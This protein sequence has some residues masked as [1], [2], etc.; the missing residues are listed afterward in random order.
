MKEVKT[1]WF[2]VMIVLLTNSI[3]TFAQK[4]NLPE[5][6]PLI[7]EIGYAAKVNDIPAKWYP[8]IVP[9]AVQLDLAKALKYGTYY[10]AE[11][12]KDYLWMED[13]YF[14]YR[15][16]FTKP[17]V[18]EN[19][20]CFFFSKGID[21]EFE[22]WLNGEKLFHQEGMFKPVKL[23]LSSGLKDKNDLLVKIY[24]IPKL[25]K[26]PND[27][28]QAAQSVKPA[29]SYGWDWHPRLVPIGIWD[30]TGLVVQNQSGITDLDMNYSLDKD[31]KTAAISNQIKGVN[32]KNCRYVWKI[33]DALGNGVLK[34]EGLFNSEEIVLEAEID[35]IQLWW[36][37]DQGQPFLYD[38]VFQ[39][40]DVN[41]RLIDQRT[42]KIGFRK[43]QL[44]MNEGAWN[45]PQGFPKSQSI[46]PVQLE[47]NGR[48]IFCKGT[49]WV[50]PEIFPGIITTARYNE[51]LDRAKEAN[52][53][54]LRVWGGGIINKNSFYDLCDEK[55]ILVWQEFPLACNNYEGTQHYLK[56][57][58]QESE[59]IIKRLKPHPSLAI[60]CGGNELYNS[61]SKMT[62]QSLAIRLLNSQCF[63]LDPATP[64]LPTSPVMGMGHGHYV[65]RDPDTNE[66]VFQVMSRANNTAY[67]EFGMPA[68][69][70]LEVLK[71]IIPENELWPPKPGTSW[72]SHH[73]FKAW[74]GNTWLMPDMLSDYFGEAKNLEELIAN[75][76]LVQCEGYKCIYEEAR[77]QKPYCSMA[78]NWCFN[79]PW[80]TAANNSLVNWPN[81]PKPGFYAVKNACRPFMASA[82]IKKFK[83]VEGEEFA[84]DIWI[85]NDLPQQAAGGK[86]S[87]K[88]V[89]DSAEIKLLDWEFGIP[90][91]NTNLSGPSVRC[92]LPAWETDCF[93][94]ILEV[95]GHSEYNSEYTFLYSPTTV[96]KKKSNLTNY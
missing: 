78:L 27:R 66:E 28:T 20:K 92:H 87:V 73:A 55:G 43:V 81:K 45:E 42:S 46:P 8:A 2:L 19:Q 5:I 47:I 23:D 3:F 41:G 7:W 85:L 30:E 88:L 94:L 53:N 71:T 1:S 68:P 12:W 77:R 11:N 17:A 33:T 48:R 51:L 58:E 89:T 36:P 91:V 6:S 69:S 16:S 29:V 34:K 21:Y 39:L 96:K 49:N 31:L 60:W 63:R 59:S 95:E 52:F 83:Y 32:L 70:S 76:Q 54:L 24:R 4:S 35:P 57:L 14:T 90:E 93:K 44:V 64:F 10:Y 25:Y 82:Q 61:W 84:A 67:T 72:E 40:W 22:I 26:E 80:P 62:D 15:T 74:I 79:E 9:G 75:G 86:I 37:H 13:Q 18:G 65:F 56:I 50:N 38:M